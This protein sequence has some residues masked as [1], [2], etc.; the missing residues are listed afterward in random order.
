MSNA[1]PSRLGQVNGAGDALA[2]F[3]KVFAGEVLDTFD[4]ST[5][6]KERHT[7]RTIPYG[8]SAQFP[9]TGIITPF[10]HTPG[11]EILGE[12]INANERVINVE[13]LIIAPA[14]VSNID[15]FMNHYD[16]RSIYGGEIGQALAKLYDQNVARAFIAGARQ[17]TPNVNGV[18]SGDTLDGTLTLAG[19]ATS[20]TD[21]LAGIKDANVRLDERDVP[22]EGRFAAFR[23]VQ[24]A[25]IVANG[26]PFNW[27]Y[28]PRGNGSYAEGEVRR[29]FGSDLIKTNNLPSSDDRAATNQPSTRQLDFSV[30]QGIVA[31]GTGAGTVQ[32]QDVT[33]ESEYDMRR[34]GWLMLGK[35]LTGHDFLRPEATIELQSDAPA[36]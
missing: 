35:Y 26:S 24:Y 7:T 33:M 9:A 4:R 5:V 11:A 32:L 15:D 10:T 31:H 21:L 16:Y 28:N 27:D 19:Y 2:T 13:G 34:Q 36:T 6:F 8:K 12:K 1:N 20:G 14:F 25:L 29:Y 22:T 23:P 30:T 3:L 18:F 17:T